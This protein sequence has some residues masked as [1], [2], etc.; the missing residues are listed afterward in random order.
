MADG[1]L[2]YRESTGAVTTASNGGTVN[3]QEGGSSGT[4]TASD[5]GTVNVQN[6]GS[7]DRVA[8]P[9]RDSVQD[10]PWSVLVDPFETQGSEPCWVVTRGSEPRSRQKAKQEEE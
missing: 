5:G 1:R 10:G 2:A 9:D 8:A 6:G 4:T 7:R 3:V